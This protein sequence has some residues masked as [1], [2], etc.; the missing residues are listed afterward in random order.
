M[1]TV[2]DYDHTLESRIG[3]RLLLGGTRHF[4]YYREGQWWPF[5]IRKALRAMEQEMYQVMRLKDATVLDGGAGTGDV[6]LYMA[7]RG[8]KVT[9]IELLD[10]HVAKAKTNIKSRNVEGKIEVFQ[11]SYENLKFADET[12][13]GVYTMETLVHAGDPN[14]AMREFYRVLKPGGVVTHFEYEHELNTQHPSSSPFARVNF[15]SAMPAFQQFSIGTVQKKLEGAGFQD[16]EVKDVSQNVLPILRLF[17]ILAYLPYVFIQLL[18]LE[19]RFVNTMAA[20]ELC[21]AGNA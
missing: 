16:V 11:M 18:G 14:Q 19:G 21:A 3:Y 5:P 20:V 4:A 9:A 6:A 10:L 13:S 1:S 2:H 7:E 17:F 8:L 12:F 15:Y